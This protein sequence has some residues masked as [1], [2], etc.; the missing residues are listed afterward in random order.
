MI[1]RFTILLAALSMTAAHAESV[2]FA[3]RPCLSPNG[4]TIYFEYEGDIFQVPSA[5]GLALRLISMGGAEGNPVVSP[6]GSMIAFSSDITG[7]NDVYV[8]PLG[9]GNAV[10]LTYSDANDYPVSWSPDSKYI[11]LESQ[12][13]GASRT[14]YRVAASGGT[15]QLM[16][17]GYFNTIVNLRENPVTGQFYFNESNESISYPTRKHYVGDHNPNIKSWDPA[18]QTYTEL[19]TYNGKDTWP[20]VDCNGKLYYVTD[21]FGGESNI[22]A[23]VSGGEPRQLTSFDKSVQYP[24]IAYNG[25]SIVFLKDYQIHLLN[26]GTGQVSV[27]EISVAAGGADIMRQFTNQRPTNAAVSPDG[28][29]FALVIRGL[30]FVTDSKGKYVQ[31]LNTPAD[32]R[33]AEVA[34]GKDNTT[35]YYTRT[36]QGP[37]GLYRIGADGKTPET[38]VYLPDHDVREITMSHKHDKLAFL[39]G[40]S[41]IMLHDIQA[42]TTSS[43]AQ[44]EFWS[45]YGTT[46]N[47]SAKDSHI[48]FV[49]KNHFEDD[50]Y[51][52]SIE[53]D[54]LFNLTNSAS[55][56]SGMVF[57][58][59]GKYMYLLANFENT[60][61]PRGCPDYLY[62]LPLRKYD[63]PFKSESYDKLFQEDSKPE[64]AKTDKK[65]RKKSRKEE[66]KAGKDSVVVIDNTDIFRRMTRVDMGGSQFTPYVFQNKDK[67]YLIYCNTPQRGSYEY[68]SLEIS[69]P[70]S[71]A[72]VIKDLDGGMLF[73][74]DTELFA[75]NGNKIKKIDPAAGTVTNIEF[76]KNIEKLITNEFRQMF[77]EVWSTLRQN[78]YDPQ[79]HGADWDAVNEYYASFLPYIHTRAQLRT[80]INDMLGELNSSHLR[81]T[82]SGAD[83][84]NLTNMQTMATGIV[85]SNN[86]GKAYE[87]DYILKESPADKVEIDI[88]KGDILTAVDGVKVDPQQNREKYFSSAVWKDELTLTFSRDGKEYTVKTHTA[89]ASDIKSL[90][91]LEWEDER[92]DMVKEKTNDRVAY[93]HMRAMGSDD[94]DNFLLRM[95]TDASSKE[96]LILDLR[97]NNGG[98][99]HNEVIEFLSQR[100]YFTWSHREGERTSHPN[101][102]PAGKPIVVLVNE[103]SLSDAEVTSNGIQTLGI[104]KLVGTETYRW[105]I[106]TSS[107]GLIDGSSCRMPAWGCYNVKGGD[108]EFEG[109]KPDIY[110]RNTFTDR[111]ENRDPQLDTAIE[112]VLRQLMVRTE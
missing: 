32:E 23:Y 14:T 21:Q 70:E 19:T 71:K 50:I 1:K 74:S 22:V 88:R 97:Y 111:L 93:I 60:S 38:E 10:Q 86:D 4:N 92:R 34:W 43:I 55:A 78:Y 36:H 101:V 56:E 27:P 52:Y 87:V 24:S 46:I 40:N 37:A 103:H 42:G 26:T 84:F 108:L 106:F 20:M 61:F 45:F 41:N 29:K 44:A 104:A 16:F 59:D 72:K 73:S 33:V 66:P 9:G 67:S 6:D 25:S 95:Y 75:L 15:P 77:H 82:S 28:K 57:S 17:S 48:A 53:D 65:D 35:I 109:V 64:P 7:N 12:R 94:L 83:E 58:P 49:A 85:F 31:Q 47:F 107:V 8:L 89:K 62:K 5:G 96:A 30:L 2:R 110:V 39:E 3:S 76:T 63:T 98:N 81:F 69:D 51:V 11:Y 105:I 99:V 90:Q 13:S 79:L 18:S 68:K 102:T 100:E 80:L 91:Y 112:E 54:S